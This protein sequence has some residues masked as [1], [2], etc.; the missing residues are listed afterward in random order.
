MKQVIIYT[1]RGIVMGCTIFIIIGIAFDIAYNGS[2]NM[3][4]WYFTKMAVGSMITGIAFNLP[5]LVYK[6]EKLSIGLK[7]LIH[8]GIGLATY[9]GVAFYVGWIPVQAGAWMAAIAVASAILVSFIVWAGFYFYYKNEA[10]KINA[11]IK[12]KQGL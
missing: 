2:F 3:N 11:K 9:I 8:M 6:T 1:L 7:I 5:A 12:E 4:S 10:K